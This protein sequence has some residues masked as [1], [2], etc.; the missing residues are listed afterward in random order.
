MR[1]E[2][3]TVFSFRPAS[4]HSMDALERPPRANSESKIGKSLR[5]DDD[6]AAISI[7][8]L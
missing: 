7:R 8:V 5:P 1:P 6:P 2:V 3:P 4:L